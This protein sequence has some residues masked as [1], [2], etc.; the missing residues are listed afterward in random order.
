MDIPPDQEQRILSSL[1]KL[2]RIRIEYGDAIR[3]LMAPQDQLGEEI[4]KAEIRQM[5]IDLLDST[6]QT[7]LMDNVKAA[8]FAFD[9]VL[10]TVFEE[11][12]VKG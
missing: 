10:A 9:S 3:E 2:E 11:A 1:E 12:R 7:D 6:E 4:A 8:G 5:L